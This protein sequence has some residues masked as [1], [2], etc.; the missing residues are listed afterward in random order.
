MT[1]ASLKEPLRVYGKTRWPLMNDEWRK[2]QLA[3]MLRMGARRFKTYWDG[4]E[5]AVTHPHEIERIDSLIGRKARHDDTEQ[6]RILAARL[7]GLEAQLAEV[8]ALLAADEMAEHGQ[9]S[10]GDRRSLH[11]QGRRASDRG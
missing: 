6:D 5:T 2:A 10:R 1:V 3:S 7:A 9:A 11:R 8:R 4:E